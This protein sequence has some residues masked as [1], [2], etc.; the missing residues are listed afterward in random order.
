[1]VSIEKYGNP[2]NPEL[3]WLADQTKIKE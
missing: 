2:F 1:L 3:L